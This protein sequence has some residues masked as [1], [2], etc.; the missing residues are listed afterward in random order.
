MNTQLTFDWPVGVALGADDFFVSDA[1]AQAYAMV[2]TPTNWPERKLIVT[3]PTG[4]GKSHLCRVAQGQLNATI[5]HATALP[6][7]LPEWSIIIEDIDQLPSTDQEAMFHLYNHLRHSGRYLMMTA[8]TAPRDWGLTLLDLKSRMQG[9]TLATID[10]PDDALL[11][12]LIMKLMADRQI[13]PPPAL[14]AYLVPRI[15]RSFSAAA[16]IVARLDAQSLAQGRPV[17]RALA[18]SLL[19]NMDQD[20]R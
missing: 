16:D 11:S 17:G 18:A 4:S 15:E 13:M 3:G 2:G 8:Q 9:T 19:D 6:A 1:N 20:T 5:Y 10:D 12:A 14:V 7:D